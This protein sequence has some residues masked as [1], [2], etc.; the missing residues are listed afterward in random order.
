M[1]GVKALEAMGLKKR[2]FVKLIFV[3]GSTTPARQEGCSCF[4]FQEQS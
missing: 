1:G 4:V 2:A 3:V